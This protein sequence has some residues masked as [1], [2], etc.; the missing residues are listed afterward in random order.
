MSS[1]QLDV[2][3]SSKKTSIIMLQ[4]QFVQFLLTSTRRWGADAETAESVDEPFPC[5]P[6]QAL[7]G[8]RVQRL[9]GLV[10]RKKAWGVGPV[11]VAETRI[12]LS[13]LLV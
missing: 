2:V 8:G 10:K 1:I 12:D 3:F 5:S 13:Q 4:H 7:G 11:F 6:W 9:G